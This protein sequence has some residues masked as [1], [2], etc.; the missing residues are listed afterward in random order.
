MT[1]VRTSWSAEGGSS[2]SF[3]FCLAYAGCSAAAGILHRVSNL[4]PRPHRAGRLTRIIALSLCASQLTACIA[5]FPRDSVPQQFAS[6]AEPPGYQRD[7]RIWGDSYASYPAG[8]L[9]R[10][11]DERL[12]ASK[13]DP[14]IN[15]RELNALTLSGGGSSGAF[16]AGI[17]AGWAKAGTRPKFDIVTGISAGALI[18][19]FAFLGPAYDGVL[20]DGFTEVSDANIYTRHSLLGAL[21]SG[22]F[23]SNA[24][25]A[26]MLDEHITD[27]MLTAIANEYAK[28][29]RLFIGTTNLDADRAVIWDMGAIAASGRPDR[30]KLFNE[31]ILAST[32]IPGIFPPV[33]LEVTAA[34]RTYHEMHVDGGTA[35]EVFLMPAGLTLGKL[36]KTFHTKVK[37]RLYVI[38]N[39]RTTPEYSSVK[40]S[41]PD[42]A[43]KAVSS[44][45]K[46]QGI[47]DLYRLYAIAK[48]DGIDFNAIDIPPDFTVEAK[49]PFDNRFMRALY[50]EGYEMG[51]GG[52]PWKKTPPGFSR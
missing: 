34:G 24:P 9:V 39:G 35:N 1:T 21:S 4:V 15:M 40:A 6:A 52:V 42:I 18:A 46:T 47:G 5:A 31:V 44:L 25:L 48:R 3:S 45:I 38:R 22:S 20:K 16:G 2:R 49:S 26:K 11:H 33:N 13:A 36:D 12:K 43:E 28:G 8:R 23:T 50:A 27:D 19:P 51:R 30:K 37:A 7:I 32:S 41:L 10:F 17:L 14:S 29:R